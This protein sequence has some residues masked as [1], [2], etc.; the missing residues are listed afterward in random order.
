MDPYS[1]KSDISKL[2]RRFVEST[3]ESNGDPFAAI[4][5]HVRGLRRSA[6]TGDLNCLLHH[7]RIQSVH[8]NANP[9]LDAFIEPIGTA[10]AHGFK[11]TVNPGKPDVRIR[12]SIAHEICHTFF[13]EL[14]PEIKF[15]AHSPDE[16]EERLCN[17][18]A[19]ELLLPE[20]E[21]R[22]TAKGIPPSLDSL[23]QLC[24]QYHVSSEV[25]VIQLRNLGIWPCELS[26]WT[27]DEEGQFTMERFAGSRKVNWQWVDVN[28]LPRVWEKGDRGAE[29]GRG[30]VYFEDSSSMSYAKWLYYVVR[31][32][33][34]SVIALWKKLPFERAREPLFAVPVKG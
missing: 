25:M 28:L 23:D 33:G 12:F 14:V 24:R 5:H 11:V 13:Y 31:R 9:H 15:Q 18:G 4:R 19:A 10:F 26:F 20:A 17:Y 32:Q 2:I 7:R 22:E 34:S 29:T 3:P 27:R 8:K 6:G 21:L 30:A 1:R 16:M